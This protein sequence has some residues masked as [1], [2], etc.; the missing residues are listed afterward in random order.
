M[1]E[2]SL[3]QEIRRYATELSKEEDITKAFP[4]LCLKIYFSKLSDEDIDN[5]LSGLGSND[6][7]IDAFWIDDEDQI[8]N[9]VQFKSSVSEKKQEKIWLKKVGFLF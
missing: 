7:S 2:K 8:I 5:A 6:E 9:I 1:T 4:Y 3:F